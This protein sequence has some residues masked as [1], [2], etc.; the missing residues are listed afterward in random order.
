MANLGTGVQTRVFKSEFGTRSPK[1]RLK[2]PS[3][4]LRTAAPQREAPALPAGPR[5]AAAEENP[6]LSTGRGSTD[7]FPTRRRPP[8]N[9]GRAAAPPPQSRHPGERPARAD[10]A[11]GRSSLPARAEAREEPARPGPA[12][13]S[14]PHQRHRRCRR[15]LVLPVC[16]TRLSRELRDSRESYAARAREKGRARPPSR[17]REEVSRELAGVT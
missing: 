10:P 17:P 5:G 7:T 11:G 9:S 4:A 2:Q 16:G 15:H 3:S 6:E 8:R 14:P 12:A 1:Q 13:P